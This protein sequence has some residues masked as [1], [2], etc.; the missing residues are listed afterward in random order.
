MNTSVWNSMTLDQRIRA[1]HL[2]IMKHPD[3][4]LLASIVCIGDLKYDDPSMPVPTAATNGRDVFYASKFCLAQ[5]K[6]QLRYVVL[7]ENFHKM[8]RH[9]TLYTEAMNHD[10]GRANR[11]MD[12]V[13]NGLIEQ[14][15]PQFSFVERPAGVAPLVDPKYF[16]WSFVKVYN[17]LKSNNGGSGGKEGK[18]GEGG[19]MPQPGDAMDGH[20]PNDDLT[21]EQ[22]RELERQIE[23]GIQQGRLLC[24]ALRGENGKGGPL[25]AQAVKRDTD[26]RQHMRNFIESAMEGYDDENWSRP[27]TQIY[28]ALDLVMPTYITETVGELVIAA[29]TSG[30]MGGYYPV[31]FGEVA[32]I[33]RSVRP[34]KVTLIWWDT[35][36]ASVQ[37]FEPHEYDNIANALKPA[38]GGGTTPQVFVDYMK[39]HKIKAKAVIVL[40]DGYIGDEPKIDAPSLWGIVDNP[41]WASKWGQTIHI[42]SNLQY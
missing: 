32:Q 12:Y 11:A 28:S 31:L 5:N 40:T 25:D 23:D 19:G 26:Y 10:A 36:V 4:A 38:G 27:D 14:C 33:M 35:E 21:P 16:N 22:A 13:V 8:L 7:H 20:I 34:A 24:Q 15:D 17:D 9:C 39:Q 3:F 18:P 42:P 29:D 41:N 1:C 30:S 6:K 2:D 37:V